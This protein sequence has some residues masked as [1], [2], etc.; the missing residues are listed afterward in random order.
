MPSIQEGKENLVCMSIC[1]AICSFIFM[2]LEKSPFSK[3][4]LPFLRR[5]QTLPLPRLLLCPP[6]PAR[7]VN[8][9]YCIVVIRE[10]SPCSKRV[11][12]FSRR[13][14]PLLLPRLL[15]SPPPPAQFATICLL[16]FDHGHQGQKHHFQN[17]LFYLFRG[18][19]GLCV[20]LGCGFDLFRLLFLLLCLPHCS[21]LLC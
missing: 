8:V 4:A 13:L 12:P 21:L 17:V 19:F 1:R 7:F 18:G 9:L 20:C 11:L 15:L 6:P 10:K 14:R 16:T 5:L 3:R 2:S